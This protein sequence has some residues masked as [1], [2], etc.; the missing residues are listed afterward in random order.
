MVAHW[1]KCAKSNVVT[2]PR[3]AERVVPL[4]LHNEGRRYWQLNNR[5]PTVIE[6]VQARPLCT[7]SSC[8]AGGAASENCFEN[9]RGIGSISPCLAPGLFRHHTADSCHGSTSAPA[10]GAV[11]TPPHPPSRMRPFGYDALQ[12][13]VGNPR[14]LSA[15]RFLI[16]KVPPAITEVACEGG[17]GG[18]GG[19]GGLVLE[20]NI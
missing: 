15:Q 20:K 9:R 8:A 10:D 1:Q 17:G 12:P 14:R 11:R 13:A 2:A 5:R 6:K 4:A 16:S 19:G 7:H 18:D 3:S